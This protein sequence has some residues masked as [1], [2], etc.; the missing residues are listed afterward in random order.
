MPY[1][2]YVLLA[3]NPNNVSQQQQRK[4]EAVV[5]T[6]IAY[7]DVLFICIRLACMLRTHCIE[8]ADRILNKNTKFA[9]IS[10]VCSRNAHKPIIFGSVQQ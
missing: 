7:I 9:I 3:W 1:S 5:N 10:N 6:H 8:E 2:M 4:N